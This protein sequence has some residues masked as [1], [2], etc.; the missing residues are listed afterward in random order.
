MKKM[1]TQDIKIGSWLSAALD[2]GKASPE[3]KEDIES[4]FKQFEK[5]DSDKD[6]KFRCGRCDVELVKGQALENTLTSS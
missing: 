6:S 4:W 5:L 2:D 3:L 1:T